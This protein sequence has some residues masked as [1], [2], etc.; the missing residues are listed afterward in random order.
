MA[1]PIGSSNNSL[2][3]SEPHQGKVEEEKIEDIAQEALSSE[4]PVQKKRNRCWECRKRV[5]LLGFDCRC[6]Y[7]FCAVHRHTDQHRCDFDYRAHHQKILEEN[8]PQ[9]VAEKISKI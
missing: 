4:K 7:V 1:S 5:G 3:S 2:N 8:N 9:V 6:G